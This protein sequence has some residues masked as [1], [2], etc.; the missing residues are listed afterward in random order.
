MKPDV[1]E[2]NRPSVEQLEKE[3]KRKRMT[4]ESRNA[5]WSA[6]R[7]LL[8]FAAVA[9]LLSTLWFPV[10][11]VQKNSMTPT[12]QEGE[13]LLFVKTEKVN[14]GDIIAFN[15]NNQILIKRLV[16]VGG[17]WVEIDQDGIVTINGAPLNEPYLHGNSFGDCDIELPYQVPYGEYFVMGDNRALSLDSRNTAVG[18]VTQEQMVGKS[19][20]R[21]W[22]L[23]RI[24][25]VK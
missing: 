8:I 13:A 18:T 20:L 6:V 4:S 5:V 25:P 7:T 1:Q 9:V 14:R 2:I 19:L 22:P 15:I 10:L 23:T 12:L 16:A 17:E 11:S 21:V 3:I 24:G